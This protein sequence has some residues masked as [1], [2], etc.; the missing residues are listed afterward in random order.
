M[1]SWRKIADWAKERPT[2]LRLADRLGR[3]RGQWR[4]L[5]RLSTPAPAPH[6]P[7]LSNWENSQLSAIWLGHATILIRLGEKTILTDPVLG[8]R[9]GIGL[10]LMTAGPTRR[11]APAL[12]THELPPIDLILLSHAHFDHLD[13]PTLLRLPKNTP[14][15]AAGHTRDL[16][17]DLG[18]KHVH[19]LQW[20]QSQR[21]RFLNVTAWE[22]RHWGART[23]YDTHR[24]A[25][26]YVLES[27]KHRILFGGDTA[28]GAHFRGVGKVDLAILGIGAYNPWIEAHATPEQAWRMADH[29]RADFVLPM[30]HST[31]R[32]SREPMTEP[33]ER[34]YRVAGRDSGRVAI[35]QIGQRWSIEQPAAELA[36]AS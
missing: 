32:L 13:R 29:V 16:I 27:G 4:C 3:G 25:C 31:F 7:D 5:D 22:V 10:G 9:I 36:A 30:H 21:F 8:S 33:M 18:F 15:V 11:I 34:L 26:A 14:V 20:T 1:I 24:H 23:F 19:E 6:H 12:A 17:A 35:Q 28:Y 2:A